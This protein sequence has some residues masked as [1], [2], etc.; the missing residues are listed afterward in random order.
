MI[1][2]YGIFYSYKTARNI[3]TIRFNDLKINKDIRK[4]S[5]FCFYHDDVLVSYVIDGIDKV[6]KIHAEGLV[7]A[8]N[9]VMIDLVNVFLKK[10]KLEQL[11]YK[12]HSGFYIGEVKNINGIVEVKTKEGTYEF[13][14]YFNLLDGD[15]VILVKKNTFL[16]DGTFTNDNHLCTYKDLGISDNGALIIDNELNIDDDFITLEEK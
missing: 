4:G 3:L 1:E 5:V 10:E 16:F 14:N 15:K 8:P 7:P 13:G 2:N 6:M 12:T 11:S 9:K